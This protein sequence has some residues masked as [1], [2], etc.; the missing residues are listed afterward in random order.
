[1]FHDNNVVRNKVQL[2]SG[3]EFEAGNSLSNFQKDME[4]RAG[5]FAILK[6]DNYS[7]PKDDTTYHL[8]CHP[9]S[10]LVDAGLY[11]DVTSSTHV[12]GMEF[13]VDPTAIKY[14]HHAVM[15][16]HVFSGDETCRNTRWEISILA[17]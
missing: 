1:M 12:I 13:L 17:D 7:I 2:F 14:V 9:V 6:F 3:D 8:E 15:Y 4:E 10:S 5:G 11:E 16:G